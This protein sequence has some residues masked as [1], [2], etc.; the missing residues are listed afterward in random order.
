M[1]SR[2]TRCVLAAT[3]ILAGM[4]LAAPAAEAV[5]PS[6]TFKC[7][8]APQDCSGWYRTDA[9]ITWTVIGGQVE[10]GCL[11]KT[12]STDT[13]GT[14]EFCSALEPVSEARTTVAPKP[15]QPVPGARM[16]RTRRRSASIRRRICQHNA[17]YS[18]GR[19]SVG[20]SGPC[21]G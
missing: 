18:T 8:P 15:R 1:T 20:W 3:A 10:A 7:T 2:R 21:L 13:P 17:E 16:P 12:F 11:N 4:V 14:S 5:P 19:R 9:A 6:V